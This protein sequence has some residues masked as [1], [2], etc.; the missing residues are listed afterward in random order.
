MR[1][2]ILASGLLATAITALVLTNSSN[3]SFAVTEHNHTDAMTTELKTIPLEPGQGGFAAIAEIVAM[4]K[5]DPETK[6]ESVNID[7]LREHLVDMSELT[8]NAVA[9][10]NIIDDE[11][12][13]EVTGLGRTL[14]AI[15]SMVPA[16]AK[17]LADDLKWNT[18]TSEIEGGIV[19]TVTS[20][21]EV[22]LQELSALG[23][24]GVMATGAHHQEHHLQ[25]AKGNSHIH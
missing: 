6:W 2:T 14:S 4:L 20:N 17:Q 7:G 13:F 24:F 19:L 11:I 15:Q 3:S 23:F 18:S 5:D 1:K 9:S 10:T 16:H 12:R 21:D 22:Q 8:M 25:M